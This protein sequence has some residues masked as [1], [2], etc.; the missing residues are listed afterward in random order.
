MICVCDYRTPASVLDSLKK[1]FNIVQLP[2]DTSLPE[3][4]C[5]HSDLLIFRLGNHLI[6]RK[7]YYPAAKGEI[8]FICEEASLE[9]IL[10]NSE[11]GKKYPKDCSL[12]AAISGDNII[13]RK[14]SADSE[15]LRL[16]DSLGYKVSDVNQ[17]Y[18]KCSCAILAD[19]AII[20]A[21]RGI[22]AVARENGIEALLISEGHIDLPGYSHGFIGGATGLCG[23][24]LY[25]CGDLKTH[26]DSEAIEAFAKQHNTECVS[27]CN[28]NL[29]DVGTLIFI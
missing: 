5:G 25:F 2:P 17:G 20:T 19:G 6:T 16:A 13:C 11:A 18:S 29:F 26:P 24:K 4:V 22:A 10:S 23:S 21:D 9:L 8:D 12:C 7:S 14:A 28:G 3:A 1:E 15:I 27:L